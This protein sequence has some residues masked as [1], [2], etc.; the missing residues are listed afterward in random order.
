MAWALWLLPTLA[1]PALA[2]LWTWW[3]ARPAKSLTS[4]NS[5]QAHRDYLD[6]LVVPARGTHRVERG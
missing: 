3:R 6:A 5:M 2:A 1:V 4:D